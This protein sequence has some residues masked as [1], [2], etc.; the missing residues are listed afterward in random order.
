MK[1]NTQEFKSC[2]DELLSK[3]FLMTFEDNINYNEVENAD[4]E[5]SIRLISTEPQII[6]RNTENNSCY[7][8]NNYPNIPCYYNN[9]FDLTAHEILIYSLLL[10]KCIVE[11]SEKST[12]SYAELQQL[13]NKRVGKTRVVDEA[14]LKAYDKAF[15][16]LCEKRIKYDLKESRKNKKISYRAYEHPLLIINDLKELCNG[17]YI[18]N[19]SLGPFGKTL[20]ESKRYSNLVPS[21][22]FKLNFNEVMSYEIALYICRIIYI[23]RKKKKPITITLN[24]VMKNISKF[25]NSEKYGLVKYCD[26]YYYS[27]PNVKRLWNSVIMKVI[28]L[29]DILKDELKIKDYVGNYDIIENTPYLTNY[30]FKDVKWIINLYN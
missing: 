26:A 12:I 4:G 23:N 6:Q 8:A 18:I 7:Y 16:G 17:D 19:Y 13:R 28:E 15:Q 1:V 3:L 22:Y 2:Y 11:Q 25:M 20:I 24:S 5:T 21:K 29:L 30:K 27:G 10:H 9:V 14:T